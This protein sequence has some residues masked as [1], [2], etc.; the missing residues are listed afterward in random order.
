MRAAT[1][2]ARCSGS[3]VAHP[4]VEIG[5]LTANASA[6]D[7]LGRHHPHLRSLAD[8]V[9]E[10]TTP[11][12]L[13]GHDVVVL[14]L[15]HGASGGHRGWARRGR[16]VI[17]CGADHRLV[18][19]RRLESV[20]RHRARRAP[21]RTA[22]PELMPWRG[23]TAARRTGRRHAD[24]GPRL[25]RHRRHPRHPARRRRG[26][27]RRRRTSSRCSPSATPA[28]ARSS[29]RTCSRPRG[30]A[31]PRRTP[32]AARTGTSRRSSRTCVAAGA[33]EVRDLASR[34]VLVPMSRGILATDHGAARPGR[35]TP[36]RAGGVGRR[37]TRASRS[38]SCCPR[39]SG[40]RRR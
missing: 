33:A 9:I 15:P 28:R 14:A 10:E 32:S 39:G 24:R 13:A 18:E 17:D 3:S 27:R 22:L 40:R 4:E 23:A 2:A 37:P 20:L 6:G 16:L 31:P 30:S 25:Q 29:S 11:E 35:A 19:R 21:G 26:T 7:R 5:A 38:S 1:P 12:T 34:P 36:A 8:R